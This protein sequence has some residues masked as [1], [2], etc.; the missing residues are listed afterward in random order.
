MIILLKSLI[1]FNINEEFSDKR[2]AKN[3]V[4][5]PTLTII[6]PNR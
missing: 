4:S 1:L 5:L 3:G 2:I 6:N